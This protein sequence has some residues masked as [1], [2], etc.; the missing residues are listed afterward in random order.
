MVEIIPCDHK[1][2]S[3]KGYNNHLE[4]HMWRNWRDASDDWRPVTLMRAALVPVTIKI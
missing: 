4:M 1:N 3:E 2:I